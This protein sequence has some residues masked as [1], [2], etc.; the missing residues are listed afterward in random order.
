MD[1][2]DKPK[3]CVS[4]GSAGLGNFCSEC[5]VSYTVKRITLHSLIHE[6][7]H[8]F[9]H[10]DKG[11]GYTL[12]RLLLQPG[13]MQRDYI[14]GDRARN[15]KPF[16]MFFL[17]ATLTALFRYWTF[18]L[19]VHLYGIDNSIEA[20][21]LHKYMVFMQMALLPVYTLLCYLI[22]RKSRFN[23]AEVGVM[24]LYTTSFFFLSS[25]FISALKLIWPNLD[26]AYV[27]APILLVYNA[28]T[29]VNF[30]R[31]VSK[32]KVIVKSLIIF[33][34]IFMLIQTVED[35]LIRNL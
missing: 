12:K 4:C 24:L 20:N 7:F 13:A 26:T 23:F 33:T 14:D 35:L 32:W 9:T 2:L 10:L 5:G 3:H 18:N 34:L 21:F 27:E 29:F 15:Q 22:F 11:F 16:S 6:G 17:C 28:I 19:I 1:K 30:Y 8:L 25:I 31:D